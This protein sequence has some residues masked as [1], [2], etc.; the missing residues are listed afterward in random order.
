MRVRN[1]TAEMNGDIVS[2]AVEEIEFRVA[3]TD[4]QIRVHVSAKLDNPQIFID[5][6]AAGTI[7]REQH[8]VNKGVNGSPGRMRHP[9][10]AL[11]EVVLWSPAAPP[12]S[13]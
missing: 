2:D 1:S 10:P 12:G 6:D 9:A 3:F 11:K 5:Y 7:V 13:L 8:V 4:L